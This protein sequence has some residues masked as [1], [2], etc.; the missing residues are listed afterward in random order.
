M[1]SQDYLPGQAGYIEQRMAARPYFEAEFEYVL[2]RLR[3]VHPIQAGARILE[4]GSGLGWFEVF[5]E[6]NGFEAEAI[7]HNPTF[8]EVA[9]ELG[10]EFG[11]QPRIHLAD[12]ET[13]DYGSDHWDVIVATSVFEHIREY[14]PI[15]HKAYRALKQGGLMYIYS[16][17]KW[18]FRSGEYPQF[19]LYGWLPYPLRE[20]IRIK[21]SGDRAIVDHG[22]IDFNQFT[23]WGLRRDLRR[24]GFG[25]IVDRIEL[26]DPDQLSAPTVTKRFAV[27]VLQKTPPLK[28]VVHTFGTGNSMVAVKE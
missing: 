24:A 26:A 17:N 14:R 23:Y 21:A 19:P 27:R 18:S 28:L 9:Q 3:R 10:A 5:A 15:L 4:I 12:A 6:L 7:E 16:T 1:A 13:W 25:R 22:G 20:R 8:I 11:V 2:S